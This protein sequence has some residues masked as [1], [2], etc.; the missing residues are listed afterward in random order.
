[1]ANDAYLQI[2]GITGESTDHKHRNWI[3]VSNVFYAIHQPRAM[4]VSTSGGHTS[5]RADVYPVTFLKLADLASPV[6]LQTCAAG[7]TLVKAVFEFMRA[8]SNGNAIPYFRIEL[9]NVL[10]ASITPDS[11]QAGVISER[12]QLA[13]AKIKWNYLRQSIRGG[14]QGNT[15]GGWDCSA[16]RVC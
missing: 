16:N 15:S 4:V 7:R 13:Y 9:E 12:I 3:E 10:I 11:G 2:D 1:M 8:D 6:L 5:G 14:T